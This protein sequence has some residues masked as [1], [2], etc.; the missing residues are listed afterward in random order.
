MAWTKRCG[1]CMGCG[2]AWT[3]HRAAGTEWSAAWTERS[4][5]WTRYRSSWPRGPMRSRTQPPRRVA[6]GVSS[7]GRAHERCQG[8]R[9]PGTRTHPPPLPFLLTAR[10]A[11]ESSPMR[12]PRPPSGRKKEGRA[13]GSQ[14]L[15]RLATDAR[16]PGEGQAKPERPALAPSIAPCVSREA[17]SKTSS[18]SNSI[19]CRRSN[20]RNSVLKS[21]RW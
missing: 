5:K 7:L 15:K 12:K 10:R 18:S 3:E 13:L 20:S 16:P 1:I 21:V 8:L 4:E 2:H 9:A 6:P 11:D 19:P 14:A 17:H